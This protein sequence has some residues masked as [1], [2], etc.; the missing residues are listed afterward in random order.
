MKNW[1]KI[2]SL[3]LV[4]ALSFSLVGCFN[5]KPG[6]ENENEVEEPDN[7]TTTEDTEEPEDN[8]ADVTPPT[9]E[10]PGGDV[11]FTPVEDPTDYTEVSN[12]TMESSID[13]FELLDKASRRVPPNIWSGSWAFTTPRASSP[14]GTG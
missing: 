9:E 2:I 13:K 12:V 6:N 10:T 7:S 11:I 5:K 4:F 1:L 3:V 14:V 8:T